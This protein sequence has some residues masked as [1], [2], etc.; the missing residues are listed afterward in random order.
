[1]DAALVDAV[2]FDHTRWFHLI[3]SYLTF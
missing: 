2:I 1:M 3:L